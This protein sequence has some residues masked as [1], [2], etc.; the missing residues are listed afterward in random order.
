MMYPNR[1]ANKRASNIVLPYSMF[2]QLHILECEAISYESKCNM[3][4]TF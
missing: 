3:V 2:V 1:G 4:G